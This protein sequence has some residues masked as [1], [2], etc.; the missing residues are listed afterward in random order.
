MTE[1]DDL[2][3]RV[4]ARDQRA[5]ARMITLIENDAPG[6]A[7]RL[8]ELFPH[9]GRAAV[10]GVTGPPG[11]GKSTLVEGMVRAWR[12]RGR[13]VGVLAVDPSSP[14]TGG[15]ILGD[16]IRMAS[17]T[18]DP[19]VY[20]RSMAS[21]A[22]LGG[23]AEATPAAVRVLDAMGMDVIVVETVGVGQSE[24]AIAGTADCTVLVT[25]PGAGDGIQ[26]MKAGV[27]EIGDVF[28]VNKADRE[29]ALRTRRELNAMLRMQDRTPRPVVLLTKAD[30]GDGV[31]QVVRQVEEFLDT[32]RG[33]G[34]LQ[35]RRLRHL[36]REALE[37]IGAQAR[38]R[39][40]ATLDQ[41]TIDELSEALW[42][43]RQDP[44]TV[45]ARALAALQW[46]D[47]D[48]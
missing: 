35:K 17:L 31:E 20:V 41:A 12:D 42:E 29:G 18:G 32:R 22:H 30:M 6:A 40:L 7:S 14:F 25:M 26:A 38:R 45:A 46:A 9:T 47:N 1:D 16:R 24:I 11:A 13:T 8:A 21:R 34:Q 43:R 48:C 4:L 3:S 10:I 27:L 23:L 19:G 44:A 5:G 15:A 39:T 36:E 2:V 37:L 33:S 28:V